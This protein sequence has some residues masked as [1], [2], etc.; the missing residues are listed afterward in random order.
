MCRLIALDTLF[1]DATSCVYRMLHQYGFLVSAPLLLI[2]LVQIAETHRW[3]A[4]VLRISGQCTESASA[5]HTAAGGSGERWE[6][7]Q[8]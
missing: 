8:R 5:S 1:R 2:L 6:H 3:N 4:V 7:C